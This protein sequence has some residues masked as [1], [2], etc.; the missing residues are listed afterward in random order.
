[1]S[2][3]IVPTSP[4]PDN[5]MSVLLDIDGDKKTYILRFRYN[6]IGEYWWMDIRDG[7]TNQMIAS[8]IPLVTGDFP[9]ANLLEQLHYK[10]IGKVVIVAL[11][12]NPPTEIPN[13]SN[14]GIEF[15]MVWGDNSELQ[16]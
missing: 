14:L 2:W 8:G 11:T 7:T 9:A 6:L 15:A 13:V 10:N 1:M 5:T 4:A 3:V 16:V 12:Q